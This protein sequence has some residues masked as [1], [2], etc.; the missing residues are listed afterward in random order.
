MYWVAILLYICYCIIKTAIILTM[1]SQSKC[2]LS[3][4]K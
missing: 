2:I 4:K 1:K 3:Y